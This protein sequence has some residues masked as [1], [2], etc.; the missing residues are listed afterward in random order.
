MSRRISDDRLEALTLQL[1]MKKDAVG[2]DRWFSI[3]CRELSCIVDELRRRRQK[4]GQKGAFQY[5]KTTKAL[6]AMQ[7]GDVISLPPTTQSALT[8]SRTTARKA[9]NA[10]EA[11]W[12]CREQAD[13]TVRVERMPDGSAHLFGRPRNPAIAV[14]AQMRVGECVVIKGEMYNALRVRARVDME[15]PLARWRSERLANGSTRVTRTA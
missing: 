12:N 14:M 15:N 4:G 8:T 10:P 9:L 3:D 2:V 1:R 7:V 13:G 5:G 11:R 6:I